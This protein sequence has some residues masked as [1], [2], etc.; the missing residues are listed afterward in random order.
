MS[1]KNE[2][3]KKIGSKARGSSRFQT[4]TAE[5]GDSINSC[6]NETFNANKKAGSND[7]NLRQSRITNNHPYYTEQAPVSKVTKTK[8]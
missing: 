1:S 6:Q 7:I 4:H 2:L 3:N 8:D 5:G